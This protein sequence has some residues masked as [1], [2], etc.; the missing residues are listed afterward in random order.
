MCPSHRIHHIIHGQLDEFRRET[1]INDLENRRLN[2]NL[3]I[4]HAFI[5][6]WVEPQT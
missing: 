3:N 5:R 6:G 1:Y 2:L 4:P